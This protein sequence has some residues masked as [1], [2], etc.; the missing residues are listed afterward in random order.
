MEQVRAISVEELG[1]LQKTGVIDSAEDS[2]DLYI[3]A[4]LVNE[5][6]NMSGDPI[7]FKIAGNAVSKIAKTSVGKPWIG[8]PPKGFENQHIYHLAPNPED[9]SSILNFQKKF[10]TGTIVEEWTNPETKNSN[11]IIKVFKEYKDK[12]IKAL[13]EKTLLPAVSNLLAIEKWN[14]AK[15]VIAGSILHLQSVKTGG[16]GAIS[17]INGVCA[18]MLGECASQLKIL[19][20]SG[21]LL[22]FQ[23]N[24]NFNTKNQVNKVMQQEG[25]S[26]P[27]AEESVSQMI[28]Q[29]LDEKIETIVVKIAGSSAFQEAVGKVVEEKVD[30]QALK[31]PNATAPPTAPPV[32]G[33]AEAQLGL[34]VFSQKQIEDLRAELN[35]VKAQKDT[36]EKELE[37]ERKSIR[38]V[39]RKQLAEDIVE[40]ELH[41][42]L[43]SAKERDARIA[44][45]NG[46]KKEGSD[47]LADL[48][49]LANML[50][51]S[52]KSKKGIA[53]SAKYH[54]D[55]RLS[56]NALDY[57]STFG[58]MK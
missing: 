51:E 46:L 38:G 10:A 41:L 36:Y 42:N 39:K 32:A 55:S 33:S 20:S 29:K 37:T 56:T 28:D 52:A 34:Q 12:V 4:F 35:T 18:G 19:G 57:L 11:V 40:Y 58:G 43:I 16:Y 27:T 24:I 30:A 44:Y 53:G 26:T 31:A 48:T 45:Y 17:K 47:E 2:D 9:P 25:Q 50:E 14:D 7:S 3:I 54:D 5:Q 49:V 8:F 6:H 13:K 22:E 15:E 23:K 1:I 21:N